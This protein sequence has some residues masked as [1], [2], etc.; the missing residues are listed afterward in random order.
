MDETAMNWSELLWWHEWWRFDPRGPTSD[1]IWQYG[2]NLF[3]GV[4]WLVFAGLVIRRYFRSRKSRAL[5]FSYA[6]SFV[7]FGI[8]DFIQAY[9]LTSWLLVWKLVNLIVLLAL[10]RVVMARH[11]PESKLF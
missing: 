10:R 1:F 6:T 2:F 9:R 4:S 8:S 5:E 7:L 11:Y 3:E